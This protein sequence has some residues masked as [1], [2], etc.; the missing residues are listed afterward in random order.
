MFNVRCADGI[1]FSVALYG[2]MTRQ[3]TQA[4]HA[5]MFWRN[6]SLMVNFLRLPNG[7]PA[8]NPS[9]T[10]QSKDVPVETEEG[11]FRNQS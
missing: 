3:N 9:S 11:K 6:E 1:I 8:G 4:R 5:G 2:E 7:E 10:C